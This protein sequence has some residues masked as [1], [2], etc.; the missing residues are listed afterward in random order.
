MLINYRKY[1]PYP[2]FEFKEWVWSDEA[3]NSASIWW[4]GANLR[5][6]QFEQKAEERKYF[7]VGIS[8]NI[9]SILKLAITCAISRNFQ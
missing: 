7:K 8:P 4:Y 1:R 6:I 9:T 5:D 3:T 2:K